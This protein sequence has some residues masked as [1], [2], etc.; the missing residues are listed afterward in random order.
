MIPRWHQL[1]THAWWSFRTTVWSWRFVMFVVGLP[2]ALT[3]AMVLMSGALRVVSA[4]TP[5]V[6]LVDLTADRV[7]TEPLRENAGFGF[8][9]SRVGEGTA[10][11]SLD[12]DLFAGELS[13]VLVVDDR[14]LESG[15]FELRGP[16]RPGQ[17]LSAGVE[18]AVV[19][20]VRSQRLGDCWDAWQAL[21]LEAGHTFLD[22]DD[23]LEE[24][25]DDSAMGV[26]IGWLGLIVVFAPAALYTALLSEGQIR[27]REIGLPEV[28]S[29]V[30]P[31]ETV[32][33]GTVLGRLGALFV[34][35]ALWAVPLGAIIGF[36]QGLATPD[37]LGDLPSGSGALFSLG[38]GHAAVL[39][40]L[41]LTV[42][43]LL[44]SLASLASSAFPSPEAMS[45]LQVVGSG[46]GGIA[47]LCVLLILDDPFRWWIP[48]VGAVPPLA[49]AV[50]WVRFA[51]GG[52]AWEVGLAVLYTL[53]W[54]WLVVRLAAWTM[55]MDRHTGE[56]VTLSGLRA[57]WRSR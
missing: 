35:V 47:S 14:T 36:S 53:G 55:R 4:Q 9:L 56:G 39:L 27:E 49:P 38:L 3:L 18:G 41:A 22:I 19:T 5:S 44:A 40:V 10:R 57:W 48:L 42:F 16:K 31:A 15:A 50:A 25:G 8:V 6:G 21:E 52:S 23:D 46:L 24:D 1:L 17:L 43:C 26:V 13:A 54:T 34:H 37:D 28:L 30:V 33:L 29:C 12:D 32:L 51:M 2:A 11:D 45:R 7:L 20:A